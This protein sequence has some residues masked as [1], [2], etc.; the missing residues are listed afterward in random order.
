MAS[1]ITSPKDLSRSAALLLLWVGLYQTAPFA[2]LPFFGLSLSAPLFALLAL[3]WGLTEPSS[4]IHRRWVVLSLLYWG[5]CAASLFV[6]VWSGRLSGLAVDELLLLLR[7]GYWCAV[8]LIVASL[9]LRLHN[10]SRLAFWL[11][12]GVSLT[13][14]LRLLE[15]FVL[16]S[17]GSQWLSANEYGMVFSTFTPFLAWAAIAQSSRG[18]WL[19]MAA[20]SVVLLAVAVNGSRSS[21]ASVFVGA[22][23]LGVL[24]F[25]VKKHANI[26]LAWPIAAAGMAVL[27]LFAVPGWGQSLSQRWETLSN[28][29]RDKPFQT[30]LLLI[31]K[32]RRLFEEHPAFGVGLGRFTKESPAMETSRTPWASAVEINRRSPHNA[33]FSVLAETGLAGTLPLA[34]L[35]LTMFVYGVR[36]SLVLARTRETWGL[37]AIASMAGL[38]LHLWTL[39][40]LTNTAPWFVFG[41]VVAVTERARR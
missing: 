40:G 9:V 17:G 21:W 16:G 35:L 25:V 20:L 26:R 34:A 13:A 11:A 5:G 32:G 15:F 31:E 12:G 7:S 8:F 29:D 6:G 33:Y 10:P 22:A 4:P 24:F 1:L 30:R 38:C 14:G 3:E 18:R 37:A 2:K 28:L 41:M 23:V 19:A 36:A 39:S 27:L